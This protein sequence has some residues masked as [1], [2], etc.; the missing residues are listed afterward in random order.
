MLTAILVVLL[1]GSLIYCLLAITASL[2][3][4]RKTGEPGPGDSLPISI[5]KPLAGCDD[6]LEANL[7][8]F[9]E[10]DYSNFELLF[11]VRH[12]S[13]P[14]ATI[15]RRLAPE[16]PNVDSNLVITGE[17]LYPHAK[18]FSLQCMFNEAKHDVI[19]MSDS[20]IR[21]EKDFCR[22]VAAE[23]HNQRAGLVTYPYRAIAG[24]SLW[25]RL[26]AAGM[27]SDFHA[28]VLTAVMIE[29]MNFAVGPTIVA[30]KDVLLAIGGLERVKDYLSS[31][32]FMLGRLAAQLGHT[33][34]L[35]C[36]VVEHRIG[37]QTRRQNFSHRLRWARTA[38]RSRPWG[39]VGQVF[40]HP[41]PLAALAC[42]AHPRIWPLLPLTLLF[43]STA[44]WAVSKRVL[45]ACVPW[46][47]LPL[48]DFLA[49]GFWIAGFFGNSIEW[50]GNRYLLNRDGTV[51]P[52]TAA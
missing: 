16:Y 40:T 29:G 48:Q 26:E 37:S 10:Q 51:E 32:D 22:V 23:F 20:D 21:V 49:F 42:V 3:H 45:R 27:N 52:S 1:C 50:R 15:V 34:S 7:R 25:S 38:R 14:A 24:K 46:H 6:G 5:L 39:Y 19:V 11:A 9:F 36:H 35:S 13:D 43:R 8:S 31:E 44:A 30:R 12:S 2:I 4:V 17:P 33:V 28:G 41:L 18:V 47:L